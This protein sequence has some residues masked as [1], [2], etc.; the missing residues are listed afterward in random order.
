MQVTHKTEKKWL[1]LITDFSFGKEKIAEALAAGVDLIQLREKE[2][3]SAEYLCRARFLVGMA[4]C[5]G[6]KVIINDRA[7]IALLSGAD[8]V[9]LGQEDIPAEDARM[10]LGADKIIG[11]TAKTPEQA[12]E[13]AKAGADY[14][15]SGAWFP[16]R[17]KKD[18]V[19]ITE[20]RYRRILEAAPLPNV[21]VGGITPENCR[22]P[23]D[24]GADGLAVSGGIMRAEN[25]AEA[26]RRFRKLLESAEK[27]RI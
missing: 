15:G 16:T 10:L 13:A 26:I 18:A 9:H 2:I 12:R 14:L 23:L 19:P 25:I 22:L 27:E 4:A 8:G 6:T 1:Y 17:T 3:S 5:C 20:E 7:D 21:A 11:V 24:C